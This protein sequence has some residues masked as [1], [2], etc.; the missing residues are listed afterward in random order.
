MNKMVDEVSTITEST[1][2]TDIVTP[3]SDFQTTITQDISDSES[4][5][6]LLKVVKD[7]LN[8]NYCQVVVGIGGVNNRL[9]TNPVLMYE[10]WQKAA[11]YQS[12]NERFYVLESNNIDSKFNLMIVKDAS[13]EKDAS[14]ICCKFIT[15]DEQ[16]Y[17]VVLDG[18][19]TPVQPAVDTLKTQLYYISLLVV[20]MTVLIAILLSRILSKPLQKMTASAR[21]LAK[22]DYG[23]K[24]EGSGYL[25]I[26]ELNNTL[27]YA[28][29]ELKKTETLEHELIANISH[30]LKTPLTMITGYAEMMKDMPDEV[31]SDNLQIIIDEVNRLN[32]L[33]NDLLSLSKLAARTEQLHKEVYN[34]T[35]CIKGIVDREN[36][37]YETN[38]F[39][40]T[41]DGTTPCF[42]YADIDKINQVLYNFITNAI[43]YSKDCK[44]VEIHEI[45]Q[46]DVVRIEVQDYG[47]GISKDQLDIIWN[48]YYRVDK[49][50]SRVVQGSGIGL[51]ICKSILEYHN[52]K[53]GVISTENCGSTFYF[54]MPI[55]KTDEKD[56]SIENE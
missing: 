7:S 4:S 36:T 26:N 52:F 9:I 23:V 11:L 25:E 53:Y 43:N 13:S 6:F 22:G 18:R 24:F 38:G 5:Y 48:R 2:I 41:F 32:T 33:V 8:N 46:A 27:N 55:C 37:L 1:E 47:I 39:T 12:T 49:G 19:L 10:V 51:A 28:V 44:K 54:E 17:L 42:V 34:I 29:C 31:T 35:D 40:I 14:L 20:V 15:L 21:L 30:D 3:G 50:H 16:M 45:I 56:K